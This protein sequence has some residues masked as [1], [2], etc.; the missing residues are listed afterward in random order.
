MTTAG[1]MTL[2]P[3]HF[4]SDGTLEQRATELLAE[5]ERRHGHVD[6]LPI[7][8]EH[9]VEYHLGLT[10]DCIEIPGSTSQM[11]AALDYEQRT[12]YLNDLARPLFDEFPGLENY[13]IAHEVG[14][15]ILHVDHATL[16][17]TSLFET[18]QHYALL[19]RHQDQGR[20][21]IQAERFAGYLLMP[22]DLARYRNR[23]GTVIVAGPLQDCTRGERQ[24]FGTHCSACPTRLGVRW[25][26]SPVVAVSSWAELHPVLG[27]PSCK[28]APV[29]CKVAVV[30]I[31]LLN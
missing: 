27:R 21:E 2:K 23:A 7:P 15:W 10:F 18:G 9:L 1:I 28:G 31:S 22:R 30:L 24:H 12:I 13:S 29:P 19:C 6:R 4:I 16:G 3:E 14:H 17:Q 25:S 11:P 20:R 26:G 8:L 5:Y